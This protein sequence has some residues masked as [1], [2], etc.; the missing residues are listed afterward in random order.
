MKLMVTGA[1][2]QLGSL[3]VES[4]L[5]LVPANS[6]AVIES[7]DPPKLLGRRMIPLHEVIRKLIS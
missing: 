3:I 1:T 2:G 5:Q 4:L 7:D 6:L